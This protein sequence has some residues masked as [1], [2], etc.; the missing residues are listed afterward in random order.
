MTKTLE[1]AAENTTTI[2]FPPHQIGL[3]VWLT[4]NRER[5]VIGHNQTK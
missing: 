1:T 3:K 5:L 2:K 4:E